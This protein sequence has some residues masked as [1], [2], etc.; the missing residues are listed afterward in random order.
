MA[1]FEKETLP[2]TPRG[3]NLA[4][5]GGPAEVGCRRV[6]CADTF[7]IDT[8]KINEHHVEGR[9]RIKLIFSIF[10]AEQGKSQKKKN[11]TWCLIFLNRS[12]RFPHFF[13][14]F[15][16]DFAVPNFVPAPGSRHDFAVSSDGGKWETA[17][18][19][20]I[21]NSTRCCA[22]V[23]SPPRIQ[24]DYEISGELNCEIIVVIIHCTLF[25][26]ATMTEGGRVL[27]SRLIFSR[28]WWWQL[29]NSLINS[30]LA[31]A[32][33]LARIPRSLGQNRLKISASS[34]AQYARIRSLGTARVQFC[35]YETFELATIFY[36]FIFLSFYSNHRSIDGRSY[37]RSFSPET[38][39]VDGIQIFNAAEAVA[40][41][42]RII[43]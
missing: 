37:V 27:S 30:S 33:F 32:C 23:Y 20:S 35:N 16:D 42:L 1:S 29:S 28:W 10:C 18:K 34:I 40:R 4:G 14:R 26:R 38:M 24:Y 21:R 39:A 12:I 6:H 2:V 17:E 15:S 41:K 7:E 5:G 13:A 31:R 11:P 25:S 36:L 22:I 19:S 9:W 8:Q 3:A 43:N